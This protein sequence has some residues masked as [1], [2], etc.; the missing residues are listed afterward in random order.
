MLIGNIESTSNKAEL[1]GKLLV[2][3]D[4]IE[5]VRIGTSVAMTGYK[6]E[7]FDKT[8]KLLC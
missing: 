5:S 3:R 7:L 2:A 1:L 4:P 6:M 8:P